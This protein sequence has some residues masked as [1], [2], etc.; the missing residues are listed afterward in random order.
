MLLLEIFRQAL[1]AQIR[2][3]AFMILHIC[4]CANAFKNQESGALFCNRI[5]GRRAGKCVPA[6][7]GLFILMFNR[8]L[9]LEVIH[10]KFLLTFYSIIPFCTSYFYTIDKKKRNSHC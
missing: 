4:A 7:D 2:D 6:P 5:S 3:M 10:V 8:F 9:F 1:L